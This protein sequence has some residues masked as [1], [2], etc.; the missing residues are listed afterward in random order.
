MLQCL[1]PLRPSSNSI[2]SFNVT[3]LLRLLYDL[4]LNKTR[5]AVCYEVTTSRGREGVW[6]LLILTLSPILAPTAL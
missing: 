2:S 1:M 6:L 3:T 4:D 5:S